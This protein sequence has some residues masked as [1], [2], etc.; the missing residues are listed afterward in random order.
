MLAAKGN[1]REHVFF[2]AWNDDADWDLAIIGAVGGVESAASLIEAD[3]SAKVAAKSAFKRGGI[4]LRGMGWGW[5]D[6]LWH[7]A[8]NIF[9]DSPVERKRIAS[10]CDADFPL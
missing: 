4:E 3:F 7:R 9:E 2:V 6:V 1:R 8:Q 10:W 5:G